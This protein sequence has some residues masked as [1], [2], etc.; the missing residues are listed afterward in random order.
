MIPARPLFQYMQYFRMALVSCVTFAPG[1]T[2]AQ[3]NASHYDLKHPS[4]RFT[5]P[6]E[7]TEVSAL[8]DID[9]NT[10]A[11]LQDEQGAIYLVDLNTGKVA[12]KSVFAGPGDYE[13]LTRVGDDLY[14]LRSDGLIH[15]L[16]KKGDGYAHS[17]TFRVVVPNHN[18][19]SLGLDERNQVMLIAA[20]DNLKGDKDLRNA[21]F[22]YGWDLRTNKQL[23]RPVLTLNVERVASQARALGVKLPM[24]RTEKGKERLDFKLRPSSIAMHPTEDLYYLLSAQD[25]ALL[26]LD[27]AG[28]LKELVFLDPTLFPKPEGITFQPDGTLLISNE[29][30]DAPPNLL[31][32]SQKH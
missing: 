14:A 25:R 32:F 1:F 3:Q 7:L 12:G 19:E 21:R 24:K 23:T 29:G 9:A 18:I 11:C 10:V 5:L 20:K 16:R 15:H 6:A 13:G 8:T 17:D 28:V 4:K 22:V 26:V 2:V 30:K 31:V 27:R